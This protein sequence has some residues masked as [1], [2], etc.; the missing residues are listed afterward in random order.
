M[1]IGSLIV[2]LVLTSGSWVLGQSPVYEHTDKIQKVAG[3]ESE[4]YIIGDEL[5]VEFEVELA[6]YRF[7]PSLGDPPLPELIGDWKIVWE[8]WAS[9]N[10]TVEESTELSRVFCAG[11]LWVIATLETSRIADHGTEFYC[12]CDLLLDST[13]RRHCLG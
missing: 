9:E 4:T 8:D 12:T 7:G 10:I 6:D 5:T 13:V 2:L 11:H 3:V 1:R